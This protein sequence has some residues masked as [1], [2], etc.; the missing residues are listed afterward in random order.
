MHSAGCRLYRRHCL[1]TS[2]ITTENS[3]QNTLD[4][5]TPLPLP[6]TSRNTERPTRTA[7]AVVRAVGGAASGT[8]RGA[9]LPGLLRA[10][11][12]A[13]QLPACPRS[14]ELLQTIT[15]NQ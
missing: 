1:R 13:P 3:G 2:K 10:L 12:E 4:A 15:T 14:G 8:G 7:P 11:E 9:A 6:N 5:R